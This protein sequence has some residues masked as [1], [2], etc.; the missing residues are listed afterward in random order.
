MAPYMDSPRGPCCSWLGWASNYSEA[1]VCGG[2]DDDQEMAAVAGGGGGA[3][4]TVAEQIGQAVQSTSNLLQLMEQSSPAQEVGA[5]SCRMFIQVHLAKLPKNLLA[6][7]SLTKNTEQVLQQ[8]PNVISSLDAFMDSSLQSASQIKTVTQLL[9]NME[10]TQLKSIL[11][12]SR[13][14]KDQKNTE[15]GEL[16]VD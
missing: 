5:D 14:Q 15:P 3:K 16:R 6:K 1:A 7:A 13:L 10:S 9:S 11:P 2:D 4:A 12:A 8:L